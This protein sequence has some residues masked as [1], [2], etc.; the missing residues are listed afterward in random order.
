MSKAD[1]QLRTCARV[2]YSTAGKVGLMTDVLH[3]LRRIPPF[4][5][6]W[7]FA[8]RLESSKSNDNLDDKPR[9][10]TVDYRLHFILD[11][12]HIPFDT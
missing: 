9:P 12:F 8:F 11:R 5:G 7:L 4:V 1:S 6:P 2:R 10:R 3:R